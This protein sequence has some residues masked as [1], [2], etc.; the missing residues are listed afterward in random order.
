MQ[1]RPP[2][3]AK[4]FAKK[5]IF[6]GLLSTFQAEKKIKSG[7]F[8]AKNNTQTASE[9]LENNFQKLKNFIFLT[10]KVIEVI[11][12]LVR[13]STKKIDYPGSSLTFP[14]KNIPTS[15]YF[16]AKN[17]PQTNSGHPQSNFQKVQKTTFLA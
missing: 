4:I 17:N 2:Q 6:R 1:K 5:L 14:A 3:S 11:L 8:G 15:G 13:N 16:N 12:S 7:P 9:Q 10:Q